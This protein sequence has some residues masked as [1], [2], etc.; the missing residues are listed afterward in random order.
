MEDKPINN[1]IRLFGHILRENDKRISKR[2]LNIK[3]KGKCPRGSPC[4]SWEQ[5]RKDITKNL[6]LY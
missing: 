5:V 3:I 2:V 6:I 4:S 1:S